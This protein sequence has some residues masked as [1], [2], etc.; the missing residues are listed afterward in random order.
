MALE[1]VS[2]QIAFSRLVSQLSG[3]NGVTVINED[4]R[5][6]VAIT[7]YKNAKGADI[8]VRELFLSPVTGGKIVNYYC[9]WNL[10]KKV[11]KAN[12]KS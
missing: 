7:R 10:H 12:G 4:D 6:N 5:P 3:L 11:L 2:N 8:L 9:D 1:T